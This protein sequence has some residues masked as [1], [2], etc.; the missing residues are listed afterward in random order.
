MKNRTGLYLQGGGAKGAF[1]AGAL[2]VFFEKGIDFQVIV[3]TSIGAINGMALFYGGAGRLQ[4][5]WDRMSASEYAQDR[6]APVFESMPAVEGVQMLLSAKRAPQVEHFFV[7]YLPVE[8]GSIRHSFSDLAMET[9]EK[10]KEYVRA[11]SLLPNPY[12]WKDGLEG[13]SQE[14]RFREQI[15]AGNYDG[16]LLDGGLLNNRFIEPFLME[17]V[18]RLYAVVLDKSFTFPESLWQKYRKDQVI[19]LK[20]DFEF[21]K[22]DSMKYT[23]E[24]IDKWLAAGYQQAKNLLW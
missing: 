18:D 16:Y 3:G 2:Q 22:N 15:A 19:L 23:K 5:I 8:S 24:N 11:S 1:Q 9:D 13:R 6:N 12:S 14:E 21:E 20:P 7:N 17:A 10:V 4:E